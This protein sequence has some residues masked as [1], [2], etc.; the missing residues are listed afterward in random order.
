MFCLLLVRRSIGRKKE[1][2][3]K[4]GNWVFFFQG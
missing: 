3:E 1:E 2:E 4:R